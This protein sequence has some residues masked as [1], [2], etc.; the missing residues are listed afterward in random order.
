MFRVATG[1]TSSQLAVSIHAGAA[2]GV[3]AQV[4]VTASI[5]VILT[6]AAKRN[7]SIMPPRVFQW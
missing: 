7:L 3:W 6:T 2:T 5:D 1:C 4:I